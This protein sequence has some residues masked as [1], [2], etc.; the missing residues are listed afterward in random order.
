[1]ARL[2]RIIQQ[3]RSVAILLAPA[4]RNSVV[5]IEDVAHVSFSVAEGIL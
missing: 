3:R 5:S 1:M 2:M 4:I